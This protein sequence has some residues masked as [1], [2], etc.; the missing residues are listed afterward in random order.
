[1]HTP[2]S[3]CLWSVSLLFSQPGMLFRS[4]Q[5]YLLINI[6][7]F[8]EI[9]LPQRRNPAFLLAKAQLK[10]LLPALSTCLAPR[11]LSPVFLSFFLYYYIQCTHLLLAYF[12]TL[13]AA[14]W[15]RARASLV[16]FITVFLGPRTVLGTR[17]S[18]EYINKWRWGSREGKF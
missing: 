13:L 18:N 15:L 14:S 12:L 3:S 6:L 7:I 1:M 8:V 9:G 2:N 16:F 11:I 5:S 10:H 4:L 17:S